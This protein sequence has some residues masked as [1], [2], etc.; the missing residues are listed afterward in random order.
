MPDYFHG[1]VNALQ[2][3]LDETS[4]YVCSH[5]GD[6]NKLASD[7]AK[8]HVNRARQVRLVLG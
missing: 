4:D 6:R 5:G 7:A 3:R 1:M 8:D 2:G